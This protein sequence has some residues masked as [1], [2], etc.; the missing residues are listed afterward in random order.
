MFGVGFGESIEDA[1][2]G[3]GGWGDSRRQEVALA[4]A[5]WRV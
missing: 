4:V 1:V 2:Q 3:M 5:A